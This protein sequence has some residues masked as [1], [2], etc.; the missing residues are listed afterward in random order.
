MLIDVNHLDLDKIIVDAR[1]QGDSNQK[2]EDVFKGLL[3]LKVITVDVY[4]QAMEKIYA[5]A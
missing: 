2:I 3:Q 5:D 1:E 4:A